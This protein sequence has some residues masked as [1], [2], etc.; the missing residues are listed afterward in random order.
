MN[1]TTHNPLP[2][3]PHRYLLKPYSDPR[4]PPQSLGLNPASN[5]LSFHHPPDLFL[6]KAESL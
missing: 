2:I 6:S 4:W 5:M 1:P 3:L